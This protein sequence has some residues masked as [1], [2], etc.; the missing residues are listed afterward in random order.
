M[1][2]KQAVK[3][4]AR[5]LLAHGGPAC[6]TDPHTALDAMRTALAAGATQDDIAAEMR[7]QRS[8]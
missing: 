7:R 1:D 3:E 5:E 8:A 4:A 6:R 2:K